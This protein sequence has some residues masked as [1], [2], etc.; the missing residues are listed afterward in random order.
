MPQA[1]RTAPD[2]PVD[3]DSPQHGMSSR[4]RLLAAIGLGV[5]GGAVT[6]ALAGW[7]YAG[8][9]GWD[10]AAFVLVLTTWLKLWPM[11]GER[12]ARHAVREEPARAVTDLL[13]VGAS[14]ASLVGVGFAVVGSNKAHGAESGLLVTLAASTIV[15][16][17]SVVH[18]TF[19]LHY[20]RIYY[21]G[22]DGGVDFNSDEPPRYS[23]FAYLAFTIGMTFQV[24][25]T[26][27]TSG[28]IRRA[29]LRHALLS[30]LFGVVIIAVMIN[31]LAGLSK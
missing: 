28:D 24:S 20:A 9:V 4:P 16:S 18:S 2:R 21:S 27:L 10:V 13:L 31:L 19:T 23:D 22:P 6:G 14:V 3:S 17:W 7:T 1:K 30:Y 12:T 25:D 26:A 15:L 29:A 11:D 5:V 8:L